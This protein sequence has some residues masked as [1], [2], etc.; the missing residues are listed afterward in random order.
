MPQFSVLKSLAH[1]IQLLNSNLEYLLK[2]IW[3]RSVVLLS[4]FIL[5]N[6]SSLVGGG[7]E[8]GEGVDDQT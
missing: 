2:E 1:H 4:L 5:P 7:G 8:G 3:E 6:N